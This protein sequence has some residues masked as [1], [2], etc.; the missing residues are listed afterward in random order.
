MSEE[1]SHS[2]V[3][4]VFNSADCLEELVVRLQ[5]TFVA[6]AVSYEVILVNDCSSDESW[7]VIRGLCAANSAVRGV[8]FRKNFG[9]D[10]AL[11]AGIRR[12]R[13]TYITIMDDDLQHNPA[14]IPALA[15]EMQKGFDVVYGHYTHKRQRLWK[16][17]GSWFNGKLAE[18]VLKKPSGV[19]LSPFKMLRLEVAREICS[20]DG[21]YPYVDGLLYRV[22]Q[23]FSRIAVEHQERYRGKSTYTMWKSVRVWSYLATN[24]SVLPLRLATIV[25]LFSASV[26]FVMGS[27]FVVYRLLN[28]SWPAGWAS[29]MVGI[30]FLGGAQLTAIGLV[31]EYVGRTF[32]N[33]NRQPQYT[34]REEVGIA[35]E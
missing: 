26:G 10:S 11:M 7:G 35:G 19:Y 15:I 2:V 8:C 1:I 25:G 3:I 31:G 12:A 17:L 30:L 4:P 29:L 23:S 21:P 16:N 6:M 20:Y 22:T 18:L 34:V 27:G 24:F 28:P 32:L 13:G 9:Q 5:A 14:D 33:I